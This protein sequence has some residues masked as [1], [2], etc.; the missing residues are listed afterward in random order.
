MVYLQ[1]DYKSPITGQGMRLNYKI[2]SADSE[3]KYIGYNVRIMLGEIDFLPELSIRET[4]IGSSWISY[5]HSLNYL[6]TDIRNQQTRHANDDAIII[7]GPNSTTTTW[8]VKLDWESKG[9]K[10]TSFEPSD[11]RE[12]TGVPKVHPGMPQPITQPAVGIEIDPNLLKQF[13]KED[14]LMKATTADTRLQHIKNGALGADYARKTTEICS[15]DYTQAQK[16]GKINLCSRL[17]SEIMAPKFTA[18]HG[19]KL[20]ELKAQARDERKNPRIVHPDL[21]PAIEDIKSSINRI[22]NALAGYKNRGE[23]L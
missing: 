5:Y 1:N 18:L 17:K 16:L 12:L 21:A 14:A 8:D 6:L 13:E 10:I 9:K 2:S 23:A 3:G 11:L 19:K 22:H 15:A 20:E 7:I 4:G